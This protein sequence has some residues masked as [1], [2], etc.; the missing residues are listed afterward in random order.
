MDHEVPMPPDR[1]GPGTSVRTVLPDRCPAGHR[2]NDPQVRWLH[3]ISQAG[4]HRWLCF[5]C[6]PHH[7]RE[8]TAAPELYDDLS[9]WH[10]PAQTARREY[11][12]RYRR[13][14]EAAKARHRLPKIS[15]G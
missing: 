10:E 2:R 1:Y 5:A 13:A 12:A 7:G 6:E 4:R 3:L 9:W 8:F 15:E 11:W 14:H